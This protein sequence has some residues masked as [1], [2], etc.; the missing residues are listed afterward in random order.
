[1]AATF[2]PDYDVTEV[3]GFEPSGRRRKITKF[4]LAGVA[5]LG[6]GAA[7]TSAAWSDNVWFG[8][9]TEAG[10][11]DLVGSDDN[12]SWEEGSS[13]GARIVI[14]SFADV[15]PGVGVTQTVYVL[16]QGDADL[17]L[18]IETE[19]NGPMFAEAI[20]GD[21]ASAATLTAT[22][23]DSADEVLESGETAEILVTV[24]GSPL[25]TNNFQGRTGE[26]IIHVQG[27]TDLP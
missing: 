22:L 23:I 21:S 16:N 25:W 17:A 11:A 7:L 14:D 5:V 24:T 13:R 20:V 18:S 26:A 10:N 27:T 15:R 8:G 12:S 6:V 4:A 2:T 9:A 3:E 19:T 1:M